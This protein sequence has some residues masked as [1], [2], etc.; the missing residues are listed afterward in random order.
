L[1]LLLDAV[2]AGTKQKF[3][4]RSMTIRRVRVSSNDTK[5]GSETNQKTVYFKIMSARI[6]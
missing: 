1:L 5:V 6:G 3:K 2:L 4:R